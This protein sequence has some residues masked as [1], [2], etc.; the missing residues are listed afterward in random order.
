VEQLAGPLSL[1]WRGASLSR[2]RGCLTLLFNRQG[3]L[4]D[5]MSQRWYA[6]HRQIVGVHGIACIVDHQVTRSSASAI[7][8]LRC[9]TWAIDNTAWAGV[10]PQGTPFVQR[11]MHSQ[12]RSPPVRSG[13][14][15][16][17]SVCR[18]SSSCWSSPHRF[19]EVDITTYTGKLIKTPELLSN[20]RPSEFGLTQMR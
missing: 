6:V 1:S 17:A 14:I 20:F 19:T 11:G 2:W 13:S 7:R 18:S 15:A 16:D 9:A 5:M 12:R 3:A 10:G 8:A 4:V